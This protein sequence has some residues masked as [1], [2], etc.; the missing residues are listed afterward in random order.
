MSSAPRRRLL[1]R[2]GAP[3]TVIGEHARFTGDVET[4]GALVLCGHIK[5]DGRVGGALSVAKSAVWEGEVHAHD[6]IVAGQVLGGL[7]VEDKLELAAT[8]VVRGAVTAKRLA[9]ARGAVIDGDLTMT[10]KDPIVEFED[11]RN[12]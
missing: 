11:K 10:G 6:A 7:Q 5:G 1:D 3:P 4:D 8:A 9:I 12:R 2:F